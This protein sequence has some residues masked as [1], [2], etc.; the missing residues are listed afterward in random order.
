MMKKWI[1]TVAPVSLLVAALLLAGMP[2]A[3][4]AV[5]IAGGDYTLYLDGKGMNLDAPP[6]LSGSTLMVPLRNIAEAAGAVVQWN[7]T[8]QT[9][10][11]SKG[12]VQV[13]LTIGR[14]DAVRNGEPFAL[15]AAPEL[16]EGFTLVPLRF[17]SEAF[18]FIVKWDGI[19]KKVTIDGGAN[20][21][22]SV[23]SA[24]KLKA[25]LAESVQN[26]A[27]YPTMKGISAMP[28]AAGSSAAASSA[29]MADSRSAAPADYSATNVQ[30]QGVDEADVVKTD[31][32]Y[33]YQVNQERIVIAQAEPANAMK[34]AGT[35]TF[36]SQVRPMELYVDGDQLVV[37]ASS[38]RITEPAAQGGTE[39]KIAP[40]R[41]ESSVVKAMI[42]DVR[43]K[44][45]IR[46]IREVELD[47]SYVSSRKIGS[48]LYLV[49]NRYVYNLNN[50]VPLPSYRDTAV[51]DNYQNIGYDSIRYFPGSV[52]NNYMTVAGIRLDRGDQ[53]A[54]IGSYLGAGQ[55]V[56]A[57]AGSL[58]VSVNHYQMHIMPATRAQDSMAT[59]S[60]PPA[61]EETT[62]VYKFI[63]DQGKTRFAGKGSVPGTVLNQYSMDE[64]DGYFRIA[65]TKGQMWAKDEQ[66]SKNNVYVLNEALTVTGKLENLAP[67]E[68]IYSVRFMGSRAY[69]V[70]FKQ[71]DPL[72]VLDLADPQS[73]RVL[74][75]LKI[76][77]YS[78][79]LHPYDETH[80]I[81]FGKDTVEMPVGMG[82]DGQKQ[83]SAFYQGMKIAMFDVSDVSHPVEMFKENI[84]DRGTDS[85]LLR[86]PKALLFSKEK[87]LMAFPVT[88]MKVTSA[89]AQPNGIPAYGE[90][91]FQGAYVY[92]A[93]LASGFK[94]KGTLTHL[95]ADDLAK[96]GMDGYGSDKNIQRILY[97]KD[98]LYTLSA[99]EIRASD[100]GT[101]APAGSLM[102]P[103]A[104]K[105]IHSQK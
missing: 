45:N 28:A 78:D 64:Q 102:I 58:Y 98:K 13:S 100:I 27:G 36:D 2:A 95:G 85:E 15:A 26:G 30:V 4:P 31:G 10:T 51:S 63:L 59:Q 29:A 12:S 92:Q 89:A 91:A 74:G 39:K 104:G 75:S 54:D 17:F 48:S 79:Y 53:P 94:L 20:L 56:Y 22:P 73:P 16:R 24:D 62:E 87:S 38:A 35:L 55:N 90:F 105:S 21:L 60:I 50:E 9:A 67:G 37:I 3:P 11:A 19:N 66:T 84:G 1:L 82:A 71:V 23:E 44:E 47:G 49:A 32:A 70:T 61:P 68:R 77:G 103:P 83:T 33:I 40:V 99:S 52:M 42:Y 80:L 65:T 25:L 43:S 5:A 101:L 86:N 96:S 34:L 97:I 81:G 6:V 41:P 46:K 72:F 76:P 93:D 18:G 88:V 14:T 69:M 7:Q 8:A 57:S